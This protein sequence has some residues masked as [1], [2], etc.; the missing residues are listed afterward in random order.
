MHTLVGLRRIGAGVPSRRA[1][2]ASLPHAAATS[3]VVVGVVVDGLI[4]AM[5]QGVV[6][7]VLKQR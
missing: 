7:N 3:W 2:E 5:S 1:A 4:E 6:Q